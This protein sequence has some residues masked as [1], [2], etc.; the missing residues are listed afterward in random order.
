MGIDGKSI[1]IS[2]KWTRLTAVLYLGIPLTPIPNSIKRLF[3][4][5]LLFQEQFH[6][7][8]YAPHFFFVI[9]LQIVIDKLNVL[10]RR[11]GIIVFSYLRCFNGS[12]QFRDIFVLSLF[13]TLLISIN[14]FNRRYLFIIEYNVT[15]FIDVGIPFPQVY[16]RNLAL[17][18]PN[19]AVIRK[20]RFFCCSVPRALRK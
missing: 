13:G 5:F 2:Q 8:L 17:A 14:L 4:H 16:K 7:S 19:T 3:Q 6:F 15:L 18:I 10:A 12:A 20:T 1:S 11:K 9:N